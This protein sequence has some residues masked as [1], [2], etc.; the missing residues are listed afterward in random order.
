MTR[1]YPNINRE[2]ALKELD[3]FIAELDAGWEHDKLD[4][5]PSL[6]VLLRQMRAE[7]SKDGPEPQRIAELRTAIHQWFAKYKWSKGLCHILEL[8]NIISGDSSA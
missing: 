1:S 3:V 8:V 6:L 2:T 7:A 5:A 4:W